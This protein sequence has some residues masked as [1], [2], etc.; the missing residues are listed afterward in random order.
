MRS[1]NG[2]ADDRIDAIAIAIQDY[3]DRYPDARDS[4]RGVRDWWLPPSLQG[5]ALA[6]V[7]QALWRLVD[8]G[9]M[10]AIPLAN[11]TLLF[12]RAPDPP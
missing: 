2:Q 1:V 8:D 7:E 12:A 9:R 10:V 5:A 4:A 6:E 3:L 11:G